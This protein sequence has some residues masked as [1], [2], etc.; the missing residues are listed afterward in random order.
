MSFSLCSFSKTGYIQERA[1]DKLCQPKMRGQD[2]PHPF[3]SQC[4]HVPNSHCQ[5]VPYPPFLVHT[6]A[7]LDFQWTYSIGIPM[8]PWFLDWTWE[9][10]WSPPLEF[11]W[12]QKMFLQM[13]VGF[14]PMHHRLQFRCSR[15]EVLYRLIK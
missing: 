1:V 6:L 12:H 2:P 8:A 10:Q 7:T 13:L 5:H 15:G 14:I 3:V 11:Q 9:F 4:H